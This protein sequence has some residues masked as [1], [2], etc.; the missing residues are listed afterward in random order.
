MLKTLKTLFVFAKKSFFKENRVMDY[1]KKGFFD[2]LA[3]IKCKHFKASVS[4][5]AFGGYKQ[6]D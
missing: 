5:D 2:F 6:C 3:W 1:A 4:L